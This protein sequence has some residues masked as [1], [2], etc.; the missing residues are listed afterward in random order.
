ME[1]KQKRQEIITSLRQVFDPELPVNIWDL[2]LIYGVDLRFDNDQWKATIV[3][4]FTS[5]NCPST[6]QII[7]DI[8]TNILAKNQIRDCQVEIVWDPP[9]NSANLDEAIQLELGLF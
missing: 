6:E 5:P 3:M 9:W 4:T 2:G 1:L 8:K 7:N